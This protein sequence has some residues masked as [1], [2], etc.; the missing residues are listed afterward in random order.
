MDKKAKKILYDTYWKNGWLDKPFV[1]PSDFEYAKSK[2]LMF[3]PFSITHD[4]CIENI[5][6]YTEWISFD[7]I[8]KAFLSSLSTRRLDLR[9][10][11][12]SYFIARQIR[13]HKYIPVY[14]A[15]TYD[16]NG[17][18]IDTSYTCGICKSFRYGVVGD[19]EYKNVDINVFNFERLKWGGL[20]HGDILYTYFDLRMFLDADIDEPNEADIKILRDMINVIRRCKPDENYEALEK[21]LRNVI[22]S[23]KEER[24][25]L[26]EMLA[27]FGILE[28]KSYNRPCKK[29]PNWVHLQHWRGEDGYNRETMLRIFKKYLK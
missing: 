23:T 27:C 20:R 4:E 21:K 28:P 26:I 2:G 19:K 12:A 3:D 29:R 15:H 18:I 8:C 13:P 7:A 25:Y 1:S 17:K 6:K 9:S 24:E 16:E 14:L 5:H 10:A 22:T 11:I